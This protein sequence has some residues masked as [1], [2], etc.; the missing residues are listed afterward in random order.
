MR[1]IFNRIPNA[2][3][4]AEQNN[5]THNRKYVQEKGRI[6]SCPLFR[7]YY[8]DHLFLSE[9]AIICIIILT[10]ICIWRQDKGRPFYWLLFYRLTGKW[11]VVLLNRIIIH[12][13]VNTYRK[14]AGPFP[15]HFLDYIRHII[16]SCP[17]LRL[18]T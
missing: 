5:Y 9:F 7:L 6:F 8:T 4:L 3:R 14:R 11:P 1:F 10:Y 13:I 17:N 18:Y 2:D 16:F 15:V 12:I